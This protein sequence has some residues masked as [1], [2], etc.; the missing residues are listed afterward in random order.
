MIHDSTVA[1]HSGYQKTLHRAKHDFYLPGMRFDIKPYIKHC[2][3]CQRTKHETILLVGFL[4]PL[5][6]PTRVWA[7][8][9]MDFIKGLPL[10]HGSSVVFVVVD[11]LSKYAHFMPI[12]HPFTA[13]K[14]AHIFMQHVLKLHGMPIS[15]VN[16]QVH[17]GKNYLSHRA[18]L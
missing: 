5:P 13:V 11:R 2:E 16:L 12:S 14:V 15:I 6:I 8:I 18:Q 1:G 10:S 7:E 4:Q 3:V 9:F 17:F